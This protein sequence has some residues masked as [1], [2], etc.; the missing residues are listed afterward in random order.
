MCADAGACSQRDLTGE[1]DYPV[2]AIQW[3]EAKEYCAWLTAQLRNWSNTPEPIRALLRQDGWRVALPSD[4]Q[5]EKA[6]RG[7]DGRIYPWGNE[8]DT[9]RA[10][11]GGGRRRVDSYPNGASPYGVLH[12][13]GNVG[14]WVEDDWHV[15]MEQAPP[16]GAAWVDKPR[17]SVRVR[18]GGGFANEGPRPAYWRGK[19]A[20][21]LKHTA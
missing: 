18:R 3:S 16:Y 9:T 13:S 14:E 8:P 7:T 2:V 21:Q 1:D 17:G 19:G 11:H 12:M 5:W 15:N 10:N 6:G 4:A 20:G